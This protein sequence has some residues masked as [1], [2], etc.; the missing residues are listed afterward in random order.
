[1]T[2]TQSAV[3]VVAEPPMPAIAAAV[4]PVRLRFVGNRRDFWRLMIRGNA[5]QAVT[6]GFYRFWLFSDMRRFMWAGIELEDEN[7]EYI[8]TAGELLIGFLMA[9]GILIPVNL[10]LFYLVL[11]IGP[12]AQS[13]VV[14]VVLFA[15]TQFAAFRARAYRLTRTVLRGLRFHQAG[16]GIV[17]AVRALLWWIVVLLTLGLAFPFM[18]ASQER[19]KMRHTYFGDLGG[20]FEGSGRRLLMR[21][22]VMWI[23]VA[24]PLVYALDRVRRHIDWTVVQ[25]VLASENFSSIIAAFDQVKDLSDVKGTVLFALIW[26]AFFVVV[27]YPAFG[28]IVMRW[29]LD[30]VRFGGATVASDLRMRVFYGAYLRY[31]WYVLVFSIAFSVVAGIEAAIAVGIL[32]SVIDFSVTSTPRDAAVVV[33]GIAVYVIYILGCSTIF[34]VVVRLRIWQAAVKS[35]VLSGLA[36]LDNV[37]ARP[38]H[39]SAVGEGLADA[40]GTGNF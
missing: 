13:T 38:A 2:T 9:L 35:V 37:Q 1:M 10:A 32:S 5:L 34:Q 8:G 40:L 4:E 29:W 24:G 31:L 19:Y 39:S 16:S 17:F 6:L 11:D 30:G 25:D 23:V 12:L 22:I 20:R 36:A 21:G 33:L 27:L 15:F 28:A 14:F 18:T 3:A 7:F 26:S